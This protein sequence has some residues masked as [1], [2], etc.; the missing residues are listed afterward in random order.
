[1]YST[2]PGER[3][4]T[5][6][7]PAPQQAVSPFLQDES[8]SNLGRPSSSDRT[9][10]STLKDDELRYVVLKA[11]QLGSPIRITLL[12]SNFSQSTAYEALSYAWGEPIYS[13]SIEVQTHDGTVVGH[14]VTKSLSVALKHLRDSVNDRTL[15]IDALSINQ[16]DLG[17]RSNQVSKMHDIFHRA[18]NVCIWLGDQAD[19]SNA[20]MDFIAQI[21]D[22][23]TH[24]RS[25]TNRVKA[26]TVALSKLL[27]RPWFSRRWVVQEIALARKATVHCGTE[28]IPWTEFADAVAL[29]GTIRNEVVKHMSPAQAYELGET[30]ALGA[31]SLIDISSNIYRKDHVRG[32]IQERL[33]NLESLLTK[34]PMFDVSDARDAVYATITLAKDTFGNESIPVDY[35]MPPVKLFAIVT[36]FVI[37]KSGSLDIICC[38]WAPRHAYLTLPSWIPTVAN[39]PYVRRSDGQYNRQS[40]DML[41]GRPEHEHKPYSAT[42]DVGANGHV[43]ILPGKAPILECTGIQVGA[44]AE[45]GERCVNGN[46]PK[47]WTSMALWHDRSN[48][49]PPGLWRTLVADRGPDGEN[50]PHW[51]GRACQYVFERSGT[52]DLDTTKMMSTI[53]FTNAKS[54]LQRVQSVTWS[55]KFFVT[56]GHPGCPG[57][58]PADCQVGDNICILFGCSVPV[59]LRPCGDKYRLIGECYAQ[60]MMGGEAVQAFRERRSI[61]KNYQIL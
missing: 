13:E 55:R 23:S 46:I 5:V 61:S 7:S 27:A 22:F 56:E 25:I 1:M 39:Y 47:G 16:G 19:D 31:A 8:V 2:A 20:A 34:L 57:I 40:A 54:F 32:Q 15:W 30:Y 49:I 42:G 29:F 14:K 36:K 53:P 59:I 33:L 28:S 50:P 12:T 52:E 48:P 18:S 51:Y 45:V 41:V 58:G 37:E 43:T 3:N 60:S 4:H 21:L 35:T 44:I 11:G 6:P 17:E 10:Y 24:S 38:P 9:I 26:R